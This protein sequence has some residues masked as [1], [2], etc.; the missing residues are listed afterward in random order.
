MIWIYTVCKGKA[1]P[2]QAVAGLTDIVNMHSQQNLYARMDENI[3]IHLNQGKT[4]K[5]KSYVQDK[6]K[7]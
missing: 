6:N 7:I 4:I 3:Y 5:H 1:N 2:R